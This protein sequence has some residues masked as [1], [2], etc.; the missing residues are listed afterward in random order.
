MPNCTTGPNNAMRA[1]AFNDAGACEITW[2][3]G[4]SVPMIS[5]CAIPQL[6]EATFDGAVLTSPL[7]VFVHFVERDCHG[8]E[9]AQGCLADV[10]GKLPPRLRCFCVRG[11][12]SPR[13]AARYRVGHYPTILLFRDGRVA[14]RLVGHPL[15]GELEIIFRTECP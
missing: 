1:P 10:M 7:P 4:E 5:A 6:N 3:P 11:R 12:A 13:V 8:C 14:R 2:P 9:I 15:P